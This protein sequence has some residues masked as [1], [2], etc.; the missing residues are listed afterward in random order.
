MENSPALSGLLLALRTIAAP[1]LAGLAIWAATARPLPRLA[2]PAGVLAGMLLG[3]ALGFGHQA[4]FPPAQTLDWLPWLLLTLA[5][6][7]GL[8]RSGYSATVAVLLAGLAVL[9]PPLLAQGETATLAV[10][11]GTATL[12]GLSLMAALGRAPT[13]G[14]SSFALAA[15]LGSLGFVTSLGG[16]IVIGGLAN[17]AFAVA[18]VLWL[19]GLSGRLPTGPGLL[20]AG[21]VVWLWLAFSARHLAEIHLPET[22]LAGAALATAA[23][24]GPG[25]ETQGLRRLLAEV[26][27]PVLPALAAVGLAVGRYF[28]AEGG[29]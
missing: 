25:P 9:T 11:T 4:A 16:S 26:L 27:P 7:G 14:R 2:A 18:A 15:G 24:P 6:A 3:W 12:L 10:E 28:A 5:L 21:A 19:A 23:L 29:Y 22:L 17:S 20:R 13:P 1:G 8:P